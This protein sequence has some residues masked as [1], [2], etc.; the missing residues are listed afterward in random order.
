MY[1]DLNDDFLPASS[2]GKSVDIKIIYLDEGTGK[3][4]FRYNSSADPDKVGAVIT[5]TNSKKWVEK[6]ITIQDGAFSNLGPRNSDFSLVNVDTEDD[7]FHLIEVTKSTTVTS[8]Q[9]NNRIQEVVYPNPTNSHIYW[10]NSS[11][12]NEVVVYN[13][14]GTALMKIAK[15]AGN[16]IDVSH[17]NSGM[18]FLQL[19]K[20]SRVIHT[21]KFIKE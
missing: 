18:Y 3:F 15:P 12:I 4:S 13:L 9:E 6:I 8:I 5:K 17:L 14:S 2:T 7:I 10:S 1:F 16:S 19:C 20:G 21:A 11:I